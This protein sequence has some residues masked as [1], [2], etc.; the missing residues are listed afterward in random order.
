M[1]MALDHLRAVNLAAAGAIRSLGERRG[2][3]PQGNAGDVKPVPAADG[4][5]EFERFLDLLPTCAK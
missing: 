2:S 5:E 3:K 4:T 1:L